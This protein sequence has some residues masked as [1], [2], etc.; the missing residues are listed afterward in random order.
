MADYVRKTILSQ[1]YVHIE[2]VQLTEEQKKQYEIELRTYQEPR[3]KRFLYSEVVPEV[4]TK[5]G[6]LIV[7]TTVY[8]S[9]AAALGTFVSFAYALDELYSS[10]KML[11]EACVLESLFLNDATR[12]QMLRSEARTGVVKTSKD[13]FDAVWS[14]GQELDGDADSRKEIG[15]RRI[16]RAF[17]Y[18]R[19]RAQ[20]L[21]LQLTED[22]DRSLIIEQLGLALRKLPKAP[23]RLATSRDRQIL[24]GYQEDRGFTIKFAQKLSSVGLPTD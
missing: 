13:L 6:S 20:F 1:G 15:P 7:Y 9:L 5:D 22:A 16:S 19:D 3:A 24:N 10:S 11:A 14:L 23:R 21:I 2:A 8:R 4:R 18:I 12:K 17:Q